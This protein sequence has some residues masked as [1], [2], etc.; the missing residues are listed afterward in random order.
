[1]LPACP[2]AM[3]VPSRDVCIVPCDPPES[4][5][6]NNFCAEGYASLPPMFRCSSCAKGYFKSVGQ[7]I[8]CPDSPAALLVGMF[9]LLIFVAVG[10]FYLNK[11]QVNIAVVSIGIDFFQVIAIFA[12]SGVTWSAA[13]MQRYRK[14]THP[15]RIRKKHA[16]RKPL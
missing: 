7:C 10:G 11:K 3:R 13:V 15:H 16:P 9:L 1:M 4:C 2:E 12:Q 8:K 6:G 5:V 14:F